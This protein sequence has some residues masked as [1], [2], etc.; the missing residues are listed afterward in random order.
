MEKPP[1][2]PSIREVLASHGIRPDKRFGQNFLADANMRDVL[3]RAADLSPQDLVL[4]IGCGPGFFTAQIAERAGYV[5]A[6]EIDRRIA[7]VARATLEAHPNAR[8]VECD[9][10]S[11]D[12]E[13]IHPQVLA[14]VRADLERHPGPLKVLSNLPYG[15]AATILI[16]L[17]EADLPIER[18]ILTVQYEVA[19]R[20]CA[21]P[22][23]RENSL[24]S[25]L[26]QC[27][28]RPKI[29]RRLPP[30]V[31]WPPPK[32]GSAALEIRPLETPL[33]PAGEYAAFKRTLQT[34]FRHPRKTLLNSARGAGLDCDETLF[35][36]SGIAPEAR[37][38]T[39]DIA[40]AVT[41]TRSCPLITPTCFLRSR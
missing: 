4:E 3:L 31:F 21:K 26:V 27:R 33:V 30:G 9:A 36:R 28:A 6:V 41:L 38:Q 12:R 23:D 11:E 24:L 22:G 17:L 5:V 40:Q 18:M 16:A 25:L 19:Q 32:V 29:L 1:R 39:I 13:A 10:L 2:P 35:T 15:S 7:A 20:V 34:L 8:L 37:P 14:A